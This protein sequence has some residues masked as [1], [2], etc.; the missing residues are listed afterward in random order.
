MP[1][2]ESETRTCPFCKE[3]VKAAASRCKHCLAD[4]TPTRPDHGGVCPLCREEIKPDAIRCKHCKALLVP[5]AR[6]VLARV[7][8]LITTR[9]LLRDRGELGAQRSR[10]DSA[11]GCADYI[12]HRGMTYHLVD[13]GVTDDGWHYCGYEPG[14]GVFE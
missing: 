10:A 9:G 1:E 6:S 13:E 7:P 5:D 4:I 3:E 12:T 11:G 2:A 8:S 14:Y